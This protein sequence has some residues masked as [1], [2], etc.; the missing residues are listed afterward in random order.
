M[1]KF[2]TINKAFN[3]LFQPGKLSIGI[4]IPIENNGMEPIAN[5]ENHL[6]KAILAEQLGFKALWVRDIPFFVPSF[7][8]AGQVF[9][10]LTYLGYLAAHTKEIALGTAS[11]AL[12]LHHPAHIAKAAASLDQL[13]GGRLILGVA[14]GDRPVEYPAMNIP[15]AKRGDLFR[16]SFTYIREMAKSYPKFS[17]DNYG[18]LDGSIDMIPKP[19]GTKIP[20]LVTGYSQQ[21]VEWNAEH[22]DGWMNYPMSNFQQELNIKQWREL[23]ANQFNFDKPYMQSLLIDLHSDDNF[24]PTPIPL[25]FRIGAN[26]LVSYFNTMK[27]IGINH[28]GISLRFNTNE[29]TE[30]LKRL[31]DKVLPHFH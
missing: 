6:A 31:S 17:T 21:S 19:T 4:G 28:I 9:E 18:T 12:P 23:I 1:K 11:I 13:S 27:E 8:D 5:M 2:E 7:G 25:G 15:H 29:V 16:E 24:A 26:Y 30:T 10:P 14:S 20:M 3:H 22:S